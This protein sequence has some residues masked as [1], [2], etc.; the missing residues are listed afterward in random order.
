MQESAIN[1]DDMEQDTIEETTTVQYDEDF[2]TYGAQD[3]CGLCEDLKQ[4][5]SKEVNETDSNEETEH[6]SDSSSQNGTYNYV[7]CIYSYVCNT[8]MIT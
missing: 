4:D 5:S 3:D 6:T 1:L 7:H 8:Y 2:Y